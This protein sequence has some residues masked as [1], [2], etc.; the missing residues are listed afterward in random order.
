MISTPTSARGLMASAALSALVVAACGQA[1]RTGG[2]DTTRS[3]PPLTG[4][5]VTG[6]PVKSREEDASRGDAKSDPSK[7]RGPALRYTVMRPR[8][9]TRPIPGRDRDKYQKIDDNPARVVAENPVS[10]FS[11]DV[12]TGAYANIRRHLN[13]GRLPPA[14]AVRIEELVNYFPYAY[15]GPASRKQPFAVHTAVMK[16]PWNKASYL[17]RIG[18]K[19]Y[20]VKRAE[21]P[22]A[23][24]VFLVDVSGSMHSRHKLPLVIASLKMLTQQLQARDR[25]SL[26]VYAGRTAVVLEPTPGDRKATIVAALERLKAG[27]STAGASGLRLAYAMAQKGFIKG[28]VNRVI[29]ATDGDFNVG[30]TN[31][32]ALKD[33]VARQRK[34]GITLTALGFGT[35][36]YNEHLMEQVANVGNGN[37]AYIDGVD[38]ARKVLVSE[39]SSTLFT[40][41]KDVKIQVEFNPKVVAEYRLIGY[42]NR[43]LRREDFRNDKVDAGDIGAGHTVTAIYEV[44]LVGGKG[45]RIRPLRYGPKAGQGDAKAGE[46][47]HLRLRYKLP[48]GTTSKLIETPLQ[49]AALRAADRLTA[50]AEGN[51]A[52]ASAGA[53]GAAPMADFR[54][55]AAVAA[56][57]QLMRGGRY[58]NGFGY[59]DVIK[60]AKSGLGDDPHGY[61]RAFVRLV[62]ITQSLS[63]KARKNQATAQ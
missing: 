18:I 34:T 26:V 47:A 30:V 53:S 63:P 41:A 56:W 52:E 25:I 32:R 16:T 31:I 61:R 9:E 55:A 2:G 5:K 48:G 3:V 40:I 58:T 45:N 49:T 43:K 57:G 33:M 15:A 1:D 6:K 42:V 35:G 62:E 37:Y 19:G 12:D 17:V 24:L 51:G 44:T 60:L 14:D 21:R 20:D 10:T 54:F 4:Q 59:D 7:A 39:M 28:G 8:R 38:E 11:V 36:N 23:N 50:N 13:A 29:L 46:F 27:G 22:A